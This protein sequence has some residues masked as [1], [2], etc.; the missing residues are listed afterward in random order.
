MSSP[1][2]TDYDRVAY[3]SLAHAQTFPEN[4][5]N[6]AWLS[7]MDPAHPGKCRVLELGCGDG[8]NLAAMAMI[9]P[10]SHYTGIDYS[11][12]AITRGRRM[13][14]ELGLERIRLEA[15]DIRNPGI[16]LGE[17]DYIIVHGVYSWVPEDVRDAVL[18]LIDRHL[19]PQGV[20]FVSYLAYPGAY[21]REMLRTMVRFHCRTDASPSIRIKQSR[22][23]LDLLSN[24]TTEKN[25]Y[26]AWLKMET[27]LVG[28]HTD[29]GF[30]HDE[31]SDFSHPVLFTDF[32][33]HAAAHSLHF[34]SEAEY[35]LPTIRSLT[36]ASRAKLRPLEKDRIL[37]EQ[38]LDFVEGR[39]FRQT[40]L[41]R[42]GLGTEMRLDRLE[43]LWVSFDGLWDS[44]P[45][46]PLDSNTPVEFKSVKDTS[47]VAS[48]P[49]EKAAMLELVE[50]RDALPFPALCTAVSLRMNAAK[51]ALPE[52]MVR[53]L[54]LFLVKANVPSMITFHWEAPAWASTLC[55]RPQ[56]TALARWQLAHG[57]QKIATLAGTF[58]EM[59]GS[60]GRNLLS[61]LD[62]TLDRTALTAKI[63]AYIREQTA[64]GTE[65]AAGGPPVAWANDP[66]FP[67]HLD[68]GLLGLLNLKLIR[69]K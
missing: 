34:L 1:I 21:F 48:L 50:R 23:L 16:E 9:Y 25:Y 20:G 63:Q 49:I 26:T 58:V 43:R 47:V 41:C 60:L 46:A 7:G 22:A 51:I 35:I 33:A 11:G 28:N 24:A 44:P 14:A 66:Q 31:L 67:A 2:A 57:S 53:E 27:Q 65:P 62:G 45:A 29:E 39:R 59:E 5:A 19:A 12:E 6:R 40:L 4:L 18:S 64:S 15:A 55:D 52:D 37:L 61:L 36:E 38:Y 42:P 54:A 10:N 13:V 17:F 30:F 8:F 69:R 32:L 56:T 3:P 68:K